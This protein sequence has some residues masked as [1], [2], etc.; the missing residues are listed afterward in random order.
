M[1]SVLLTCSGKLIEEE[2]ATGRW[3]RCSEAAV[4]AASGGDPA[5]EMALT[6]V[7]WAEY[8]PL[9]VEST[10]GA[11]ARRI[12]GGGLLGGG[13]SVGVKSAWGRSYL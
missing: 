6:A 10:Q 9:G 3:F 11:L 7:V 13:G 12:D 5:Q 4:R 8:P 2:P 1:N